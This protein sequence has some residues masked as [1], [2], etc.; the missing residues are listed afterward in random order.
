MSLLKTKVQVY[1]III[2]SQWEP[3]LSAKGWYECG[4]KEVYSGTCLIRHPLGN[5]KQA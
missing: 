4:A 5:V 3:T 1:K 2:A